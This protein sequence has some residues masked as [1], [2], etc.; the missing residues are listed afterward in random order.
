[1]KRLFVSFMFIMPL[2]ACGGGNSGS[3]TGPSSLKGITLLSANPASGATITL[4]PCVPDECSQALTAPVSLSLSVVSDKDYNSPSDLLSVTAVWQAA[5]KGCGYG[6]ADL[7]PLKANR[8]QTVSIDRIEWH[9]ADNCPLPTTASQIE[10]FV[11]REIALD[12]LGN[13]EVILRDTFPASY[14]FVASTPPGSHVPACGA[15]DPSDDATYACLISTGPNGTIRQIGDGQCKDGSF[16]CSTD[17]PSPCSG[18]DGLACVF[19]PGN[20]CR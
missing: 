7:G 8:P 6:S 18:H 3:S 14:R 19:C 11:S 15:Y 10:A 9:Y 5:G 13:P 16:A 4:K 17:T 2:A 12:F 20:L 1:M